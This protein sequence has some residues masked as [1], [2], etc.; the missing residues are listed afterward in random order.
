MTSDLEVE[1][2]GKHVMLS[3]SIGNSAAFINAIEVVSA[4]NILIADKGSALFP[5][6][7]F[8]GLTSYAFQPLYRLNNGRSL[9][10]SVNDTLGRVWVS[11]QPFIA[12][13]NAANSVSVA[14]DAIRF[15]NN[16][17]VS[18]LIAPQTVY[19]S[20]T[21]MVDNVMSTNFNITWN[22][23][24]D[25]SFSYLIRLHFCDIAST[26]LNELYFNVYVNQKMAV[27]NLDLSAINGALAVPYYKDIV[28]NASLMTE[29]L[30]VQI[31]PSNWAN[32][33]MNGIEVMKMSNSV[34]SL[35]GEFGVDGSKEGDG[36]NRTAVAVVGFAIMFGAFVGLGAMVVKWQKRPQDWERRK[37]FSSWLLPFQAASEFEFK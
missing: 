31:G 4:P 18:P 5:V 20:A 3:N 15:P 34:N 9:I 35:D 11:D 26:G 32:A 24:G 6:G 27:S 37:S 1:E 25:N 14:T 12:N 22:F 23:D 17:S 2:E 13:I 8:N 19:A 21:E 30:T 36:S 33:I 28:V 16:P 10:T 7:D 29:G